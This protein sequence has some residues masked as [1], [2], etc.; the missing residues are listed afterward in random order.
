[1]HALTTNQPTTTMPTPKSTTKP[2]VIY[3]PAADDLMDDDQI[4]ANL[5]GQASNPVAKAVL[6]LLDR[7]A[8]E[9]ASVAAQPDAV[10][11]THANGQVYAHG[12]LA[13][14]IREY[15]RM[16]DEQDAPLVP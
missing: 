10:N 12:L 11:P 16:P 6:A 3:I 4:Q 13:N 15:L 7:D 2:K 5:A 8:A 1:M 9:A 14:K